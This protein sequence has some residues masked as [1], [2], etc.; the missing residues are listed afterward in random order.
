ML[1]DPEG[2]AERIR[3]LAERGEPATPFEVQQI[4]ALFTERA[5]PS[6]VTQKVLQKYEHHV[7]DRFEWPSDTTPEEY[8][9]SLH[10]TVASEHTGIYAVFEMEL[11]DWVLYFV[12]R[13]RR[14]WRG[15]R[16]GLQVLVLFKREPQRWITGFQARD[17]IDYVEDQVGTWLF[18]PG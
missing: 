3:Q 9:E 17:G 1:T 5:L 14:A 18:R 4:R 8:L 13:V 15:R 11:D 16:A 7:V 10:A 2:I 6:A 12:G